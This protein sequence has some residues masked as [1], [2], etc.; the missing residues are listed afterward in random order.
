MQLM[1]KAVVQMQLFLVLLMLNLSLGDDANGLRVSNNHHLQQITGK[2]GT[3][4][5]ICQMANC[6]NE[7]LLA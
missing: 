3:L 4:G 6:K 5:R 2:I 1:S 7:A